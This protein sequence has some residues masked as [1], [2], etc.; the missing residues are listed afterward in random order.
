MTFD[1]TFSLNKHIH[2]AHEAYTKFDCE[3]CAKTFE[4]NT[5][6]NKHI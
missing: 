2:R 3:N 1:N 4:Y 6:L 5:G